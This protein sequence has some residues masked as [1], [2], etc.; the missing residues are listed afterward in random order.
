MIGIF[1]QL[2]FPDPPDVGQE[3]RQG[4][5]GQQKATGPPAR[6][7]QGQGQ[8]KVKPPRGAFDGRGPAP[9]LRIWS[10]PIRPCGC[11]R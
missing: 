10:C 4:A 7:R 1:S 6:Q 3:R 8:G 9:D 5:V 11:V 2:C